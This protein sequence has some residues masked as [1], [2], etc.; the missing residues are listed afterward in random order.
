V[1]AVVLVWINP[2]IT[3]ESSCQEGFAL[4]KSLLRS[5]VILAVED[6]APSRYLLSR[7]LSQA[8]YEVLE[9]ATGSEALQY[10][11]NA[12]AIVLD[13]HLPDIVGYEVC[14]RLKQDPA[15][16]HVPVIFLTATAH[17]PKSVERGLQAGG[18][19]YLREPIENETLIQTIKH[20]L[21]TI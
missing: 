13:V 16:A 5:T 20:L 21:F 19:A 4:N 10:A 3:T 12:D 1:L 18:A 7:N 17:D 9:A 8:G 6:Y 14:R 2:G 15:T 11:P